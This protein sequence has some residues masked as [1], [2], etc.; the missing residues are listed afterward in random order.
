M[1]VWIQ[2]IWASFTAFCVK[3]LVKYIALITQYLYFKALQ[4][5]LS[6]NIYYFRYT[7]GKAFNYLING[8]VNSQL[9]KLPTVKVEV[10]AEVPYSFKSILEVLIVFLPQYGT[11]KVAI[12]LLPPVASYILSN[13]MHCTI[14]KVFMPVI[15]NSRFYM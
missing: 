11:V 12:N 9:I 6:R 8:K 15:L 3:H 7:A 1:P 2:I 14:T 4:R 10:L 13:N 5:W